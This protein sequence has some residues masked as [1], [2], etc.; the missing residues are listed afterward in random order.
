MSEEFFGKPFRATLIGFG[1]LF[2]LSVIAYFGYVSLFMLAVIG[3]GTIVATYKKLEYGLF[4]AFIE[5]LSNAH[6]YLISEHIGPLRVSIR[7][8]IFLAVFVGWMIAMLVRRNPVRFRDS[9]MISFLPLIFAIVIG[10]IVGLV[11]RSAVEVFQDGNAYL[12]L[13]YLLPVLHVQWDSIKQRVILQM[14]AA[15]TIF[16]SVVSILLLYAY[17]HFSEP[18]LKIVYVYLRDIRFAEITNVGMGIY[19]IFEQTQFFAIIFGLLI[20]PRLFIP[21]SKRDRFVTV[22]TLSLVAS[23]LLISMSRSF[24]FGAIGAVFVIFLAMIIVYKTTIK[25]FIV[26]MSRTLLVTAL[27]VLMLIAAVAFPFPHDRGAADYLSDIFG[28]RVSES[29]VAISSRWNLLGPMIDRIQLSPVFGN[30]FGQTVTFKTDDPRARAI[31]PDGTWTTTSMEWGWFELWLKMGVFGPMA[32]LFL[33]VGIIRSAMQLFHT[34]KTWIAI[35]VIATM[36]FVYFTHVFSP[37]LNHPIGI[38]MVIAL[39]PF[40]SGQPKGLFQA[41]AKHLKQKMTRVNLVTSVVTL[42]SK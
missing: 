42:E 26:G 2:G 10:G 20:L 36:T 28:A 7:M 35:W 18:V 14:L 29:D 17:T 1:V 19:R 12:Y 32:F 31:N 27:G 38:G 9:R 41:W 33:Y 30:G 6:G 8:V 21:Q 23:V 16:S 39:V 11:Q 4:I 13:C 5:L 37:Y 3:I 15:A 34:E 25:Q 22:G 24:L 40:L